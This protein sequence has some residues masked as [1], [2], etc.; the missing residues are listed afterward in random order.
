MELRYHSDASSFYD[1][2]GHLYPEPIESL[3]ILE[4]KHAEVC[5]KLES[6]PLS[7]PACEYSADDD[8]ML[9]D[10]GMARFNLCSLIENLEWKVDLKLLHSMNYTQMNVYT[11]QTKEEQL[12]ILQEE[13]Q[14]A[15]DTYQ[16]SRF[17]LC[18][19]L[20]VM[21]DNGFC[22]P[23]IYNY[24]TS[25][26]VIDVLNQCGA[27]VGQIVD[28][29]PNLRDE[30]VHGATL[31]KIMALHEDAVEIDTFMQS[32]LDLPIQ[33]PVSYLNSIE[34]RMNCAR[35]SFDIVD[36]AYWWSVWNITKVKGSLDNSFWEIRRRLSDNSLLE[37]LNQFLNVQMEK[38][39]LGNYV[40]DVFKNPSMDIDWKVPCEVVHLAIRCLEH[41]IDLD[42]LPEA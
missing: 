39:S 12:K 13:W 19:Y 35:Q 16:L 1:A 14:T 11:K 9:F 24:L 18:C 38:D 15:I 33:E 34:D 37:T 36:F 7:K 4:A 26:P 27:I 20:K 8:D 32:Y 22:K 5:K 25:F 42:D 41:F 6:L 30:V 10:L 3:D 21:L 23:N 31:E 40:Y 29:H 17:V 2:E 28:E